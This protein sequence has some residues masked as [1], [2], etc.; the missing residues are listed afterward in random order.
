MSRASTSV[1][2]DNVARFH[3]KKIQ[4]IRVHTVDAVDA[5][6]L[7]VAPQQEEVF[8]VLDLIRQHQVD[9]LKAQLSTIHII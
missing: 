9:R 2:G 5:R 6:A 7:V 1:F 8:R 3:V 4:E